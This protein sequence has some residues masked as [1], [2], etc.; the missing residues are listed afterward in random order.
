MRWEEE[1][2]GLSKRIPERLWLLTCQAPELQNSRT[3]MDDNECV[4][5]GLLKPGTFG[6]Y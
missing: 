3:A 4:R 6:G 5:S 1:T 2:F